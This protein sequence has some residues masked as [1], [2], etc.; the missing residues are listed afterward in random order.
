MYVYSAAMVGAV[1]ILATDADASGIR[2]T[3]PR[4][5]SVLLPRFV[6]ALLVALCGVITEV[7]PLFVRCSWVAVAPRCPLAV[8]VTRPLFFRCYPRCFGCVQYMRCPP[9]FR[10]RG[11]V[12]VRLLSAC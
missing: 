9:V 12:V 4:A 3:F 11:G 7:S 5:V 2:P 1:M 8:W 6:R 10:L